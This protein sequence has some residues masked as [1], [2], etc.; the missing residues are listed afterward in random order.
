MNEFFAWSGWV[1]SAITTIF[2]VL[3]YFEKNKYKK[4]VQKFNTYSNN[5]IT[6]NITAHDN[7]IAMERNE[8]GIH[9]G[10]K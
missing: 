6:K 5:T 10:K 3:Q 4:Q 2:G 8:G 9:I 7:G 1:F